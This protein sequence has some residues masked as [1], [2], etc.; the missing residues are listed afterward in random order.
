MNITQ[1]FT[2][3]SRYTSRGSYTPVAIVLHEINEP[4]SAVDSRAGSNLINALKPTAHQSYH[5]V[6][7]GAAF[8]SYVDVDFA[9]RSIANTETLTGWDVQTAY[10]GVDP[11]LYTINIGIVIGSSH[12]G[13]NQ[14]I[15]C[16]G[17]AYA[18]AMMDALQRLIH[19]LAT[20]YNIDVSGS[21]LWLHNEELC[22]LCID[23]LRSVPVDPGVGQEDWFCDRLNDMPP[24]DSNAP[25]LV[26]SDCATYTPQQ[27]VCSVVSM[28]EPGTNEN[29][30]LVGT[31][32]KA[33]HFPA[34]PPAL[35]DVLVTL[36]P[37]IGT[38]IMLVGTDCK[39]YPSY[40]VVKDGL[41]LALAD[42]TTPGSDP[43]PELIGNDCA[44]YTPQAIVCNA[45]GALSE[46]PA[47]SPAMCHEQVV[48]PDC[49]TIPLDDGD[50]EIYH[51]PVTGACMTGRQTPFNNTA[52]GEHAIAEGYATIASGLDSHAEGQTT[53]A[54]GTAAHAEGYETIASGSPSHAEGRGTQATS[55][56][57][58]AEGRDTIASG[59][60]SHAEGTGT[61]ASAPHSH[62]EGDGTAAS[63]TFAHAEGHDTI[64]SGSAAHAE[65]EYTLAAGLDSHAQNR[66]TEA[67]GAYS[68]ATGYQSRAIMKGETAEA[69]GMFETPGDA[70]KRT[71][72]WQLDSIVQDPNSYVPMLIRGDVA[73]LPVS[74]GTAQNWTF[75][76]VGTTEDNSHVWMFNVYAAI[77]NPSGVTVLAQT[78]Q[79]LFSSDSQYSVD[80]IPDVV[81]GTFKLRVYKGATA[82]NYHIRWYAFGHAA[83]I[84]F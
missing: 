18:P 49:K 12:L 67:L 84:I 30:A 35:C 50:W 29:P 7:D 14:C 83:Q 40:I 43:L 64:A 17:R 16:C 73:D 2:H 53:Q 75:Q 42:L 79:T 54:L 37:T 23:D 11:D 45:L 19:S 56:S 61:T 8:Y 5:Y 4:I 20:L 52:S 55:V 63:G 1:I 47:T 81:N 25:K 26:G 60:A 70:Q 46:R 13:D 78:L 9:S 82:G 62:A 74:P 36:P 39:A 31:D 28:L 15:P 44:V 65:G 32:C 69:N 51:D 68:S 72:H 3:P 21:G 58:H 41:C 59:A 80:I 6:L 71:I 10:P 34:P 57:A 48:T 77:S 33:Y 76:I 22:D 27:V 66:E 38:D 24:G